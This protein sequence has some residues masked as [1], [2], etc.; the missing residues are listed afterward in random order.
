MTAARSSALERLYRGLDR[1]LFGRSRW[2]GKAFDLPAADDVRQSAEA[3]VHLAWGEE[4]IPGG[5]VECLWVDYEG[6]PAHGLVQAV[7]QRIGQPGG[8]VLARV[9]L[10]SGEAQPRLLMT[11]KLRLEH[12]SLQRSVI[13]CAAKLPSLIQGALARRAV[14][15]QAAPGSPC[16]AA[17]V[18]APRLLWQMLK[19]ALA[20]L[21]GREQWVIELGRRHDN[22]TR[23][24]PTVSRLDP[25]DTA[26]WADPFL[27]R[28]GDRR[29]VLFEELPFRTQRG[30][31][32]RVEIDTAGRPVGPAQVV[33]AEPW[34]LSYPFVWQE[35]GR[36]F[37]LPEASETGGTTLYEAVDGGAAWR[38]HAVLIEGTRLADATIVRYDGRLWMFASSTVRGG[39]LDDALHIYYAPSVEG[40]WHAHPLNPV[41]VDASSSRPAGAMWVEGG[42]LYRV[43]QD[44]STRYGG[45][46]VCLRVSRLTTDAFEEETVPGW[47]PAEH[48][49]RDPWHTFN[50]SEGLTVTDRLL[51]LPRWRTLRARARP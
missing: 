37:L 22:A 38:R 41:K 8:M 15:L 51:T 28:M 12:R 19:S 11:G 18:S 34:H 3:A 45:A 13:L 17:P 16:T 5:H 46:T 36:T 35:G 10:R 2:H 29:Y 40:P 4:S 23:P 48:G 27:V 33:L 25:P 47:G 31:I 24:G 49:Q 44:C 30:H 6:L 42:V 43:A 50:F 39:A 9:W 14:S 20:W 7:R 26:F 1:Q 21:R 32:S